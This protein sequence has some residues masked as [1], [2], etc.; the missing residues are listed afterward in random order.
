MFY[1]HFFLIFIVLTFDHLLFA[2]FFFLGSVVLNGVGS[3]VTIMGALISLQDSALAC[4]LELPTLTWSRS[5]LPGRDQSWSTPLRSFLSFPFCLKT[6]KHSLS[7]LSHFLFLSFPFPSFP[8]SFFRA[9]QM[10]GALKELHN[11]HKLRKAEFFRANI[12]TIPAEDGR[13]HTKMRRSPEQVEQL[14]TFLATLDAERAQLK[15]NF[16]PVTTD[17]K[18]VIEEYK[19]SVRQTLDLKAAERRQ[20]RMRALGVAESPTFSS[21]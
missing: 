3:V 7:F 18:R 6:S 14:R 4:S 20:A 8:L 2:L 5:L 12:P 9:Q 15:A 19:Q 13:G 11:A 10:Q 1:F 17:I 16:K 21:S